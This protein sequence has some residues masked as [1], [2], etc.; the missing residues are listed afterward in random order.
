MEHVEPFGARAEKPRHWVVIAGLLTTALALLG[1]HWLDTH[2]SD[3]HVMGWYAD[4][5]LPVGAVLVGAAAGSGYGLASWRSGVK[6]G[7]GLLWLIVVLQTGAYFTAQYVEFRGMA[8]QYDDGTPVGFFEYLDLQ[9]RSFAWQERNGTPGQPLGA[10]G[11]GVRLLEITGFVGGG[12]L[13]PIGLRRRPYCDGCQIYLREK[14]VGWLPAGVLP[15]KVKK[16]DIEG[17][18]AYARDREQTWKAGRE[19]LE[20][21]SQQAVAGR[22]ADFEQ[23]MEPHAANKKACQKLERRIHLRLFT[24][25]ECRTGFLD[26]QTVEGQ[27]KQIRMTPLGR[28]DVARGFVTDYIRA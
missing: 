18:A 4:Y 23:L 12:L 5:V 24:C 19:Q 11:Y 10:W 17:Q 25:P 14:D 15:R 20:A 16:K 28:W 6:I 9:A 22:A 27:G 3:F 7:R 8:L 21:I 2:T 1:V 13:I 26:A